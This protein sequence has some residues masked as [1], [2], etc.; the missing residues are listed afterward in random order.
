AGSKAKGATLY[1]NLEPCCHTDKRTP[2]C[3]RAI[4]GS[5]IKKV[6]VAMTDPNPKVS[7]RGIKELKDAGIETIVGVMETE[8]RKL[9]ESFAKFI[10]KREPFVILKIAQSLDGN[11]ATSKGESKWITGHKAR[12]YVHRLRNDVDGLLVGIGTVIKDDPSLDCRIKGG[13]NPY[14]IIVDSRLKIPLDSKVLKYKDNKTIIATINSADNKKSIALRSLGATVLSVR[15]KDGKVDL[16]A[17]MKELGRLDITSIMIEGG[18]SIAASA[19]SDKIVDKVMFFMA[20]KIMGGTDSIHSIG[21]KSPALLRNAVRL[22]N[23][24]SAFHGDDILVEGYL[25]T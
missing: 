12:E 6:V 3:T 13:K 9:N 20:P 5:G 10:R 24:Q 25:K 8:A 23:M 7:G 2:P 11:I 14:R 22:I 18:S 21:G 17:L 16:K 19:I 4:I 15:D 1:V